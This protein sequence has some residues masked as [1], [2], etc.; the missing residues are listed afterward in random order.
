[1]ITGDKVN[2]SRSTE[3]FDKLKKTDTELEGVL[4]VEGNNNGFREL[5][6]KSAEYFE[7]S[8]NS[9]YLISRATDT[10]GQNIKKRAEEYSQSQ[11]PTPNM[12]HAKWILKRAAKNM[13]QFVKSAELEMPIFCNN[14][15]IGIK[16]LTRAE[17]VLNDFQGENQDQIYNTL[18]SIRKLKSEII[19]TRASIK[20]MIDAVHKLPRAS[21][22]LNIAKNQMETALNKLINRI[23]LAADLVSE[24]EKKLEKWLLPLK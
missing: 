2:K 16:T 23:D 20:K 4:V 5:V 1:L 21:R 24:A 15:S 13:G 6:E 18:D 17:A 9:I 11:N 10:V 8:T 12:K 7:I 14:F 19:P 22:D 3:N